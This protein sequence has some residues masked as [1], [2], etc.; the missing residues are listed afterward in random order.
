MVGVINKNIV[1]TDMS[2]NEV[3]LFEGSRVFVE[4]VYQNTEGVDVAV[5]SNIHCLGMVI[6]FKYLTQ[7]Y[8]N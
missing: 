7:E 5:V 6:E 1:I 4:V 8:L 2:N 3:Y